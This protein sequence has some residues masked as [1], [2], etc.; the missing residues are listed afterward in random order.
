MVPS[1]VYLYQGNVKISEKQIK[2]VNIEE[3]DLHILWT[4]WVVSIKFSGMWLMI[5]SKVT[6][7]QGASLPIEN[8]FLEKSHRGQIDPQSN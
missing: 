7:K 8:T 5:I 6:K 2:I 3:E 4:T 1:L